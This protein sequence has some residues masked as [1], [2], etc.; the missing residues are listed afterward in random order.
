MDF[1]TIKRL[2]EISGIE[3][4]VRHNAETDGIVISIAMGDKKTIQFYFDK[5]GFI[6][7]IK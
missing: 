5:N 3:Y 6:I 7:P 4:D 2:L 1:W